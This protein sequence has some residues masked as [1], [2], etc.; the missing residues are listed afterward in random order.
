MA[1]PVSPPPVHAR[2]VRSPLLTRNQ[3]SVSEKCQATRISKERSLLKS[4]ATV[5]HS[6]QRSQASPPTPLCASPLYALTGTTRT[7]MQR[8]R[9]KV[10][11]CKSSYECLQIQKS[12]C[13]EPRADPGA[14]AAGISWKGGTHG[15]DGA[16]C[17]SNCCCAH[18]A[19]KTAQK[20]KAKFIF[21][22]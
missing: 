4:K 19:Q 9:G 21:C 10:K 2:H 1:P 3:T 14:S 7:S 15:E 5:R 22:S 6:L 20:S 16:L 13:K 18:W 8:R 11:H 17:P 12:Q